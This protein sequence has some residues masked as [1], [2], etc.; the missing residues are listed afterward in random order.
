MVRTFIV[1][2][3]SKDGVIL[4]ER[5]IVRK[6]SDSDLEDVYFWGLDKAKE[7]YWILKEVIEE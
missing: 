3:L 2:Y 1:K 5:V 7:N 4:E 6:S